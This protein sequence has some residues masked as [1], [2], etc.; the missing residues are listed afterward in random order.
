[1]GNGK[2]EMGIGRS[3]PLWGVSAPRHNEDRFQIGSGSSAFNIVSVWTFAFTA[4]DAEV[5]RRSVGGPSTFPSLF[6]SEG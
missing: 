2:R 1:M 6:G 3:G 4:K 5:A